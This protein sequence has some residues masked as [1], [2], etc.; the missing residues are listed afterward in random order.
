MVPFEV[1]IPPAEQDKALLD[2]LRTE[3]PGV[4]AWLVR[5]CL[6]RPYFYEGAEALELEEFLIRKHLEIH[7]AIGVG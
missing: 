5:G 3:W 4:L 7:A 2:K 6:A 1:V